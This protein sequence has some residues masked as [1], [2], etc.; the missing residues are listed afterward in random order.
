[1]P[2][3]SLKARTISDRLMASMWL[4]FVKDLMT[5]LT[6]CDYNVSLRNDYICMV[7]GPSNVSHKVSH[8]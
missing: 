2:K 6:S 5:V 1:M 7:H 4:V 3:G 8:G